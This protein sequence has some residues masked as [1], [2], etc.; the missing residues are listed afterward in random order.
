[1]EFLCKRFKKTL[2]ILV[3][4]FE[5][6]GLNQIILRLRFCLSLV[7]GS[8]G[9]LGLKTTF[10][11]NS[12]LVKASLYVP[13]LF[14]KISSSDDNLEILLL[15]YFQIYFLTLF[16]MEEGGG[17][18]K[19]SYQFFVF[20]FYKSKN[21][22]SKLSDFYFSLFRHTD[23]KFQVRTYCQSQIIK[24]EPRSPLKKRRFSGQILVKLRLDNF[25]HRNP[26]ITKRW[27]HDHF[28]NIIWITWQVFV[29]DVMDINYDV[30]IFISKYFFFKKV[31]GSHFCWHHQNFN[32]F[33]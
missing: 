9:V 24:L 26:R 27:S 11:W 32:F 23:V 16:R 13:I 30:I 12:H 5:Y 1:M 31:W 28:Y 8:D 22:P 18:K 14:L 20:N 17:D 10:S 29:A 21:Q 15:M 3:S 6:G 19:K 4:T 25:S 7:C 33:Y 2:P